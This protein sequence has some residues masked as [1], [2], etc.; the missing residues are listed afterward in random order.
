MIVFA[1]KE[2]SPKESLGPEK[3]ASAGPPP[4]S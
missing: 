3:A 1:E 4:D 2:V